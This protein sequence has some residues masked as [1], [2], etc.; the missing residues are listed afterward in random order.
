MP[1]GQLVGVS[2]RDAEQLARDLY[3]AR[4]AI[5]VANQVRYEKLRNLLLYASEELTA[6]LRSAEQ[7]G[8]K[9]I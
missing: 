5:E 3:H 6:L 7:R 8:D 1:L 9:V 2:T 4:S